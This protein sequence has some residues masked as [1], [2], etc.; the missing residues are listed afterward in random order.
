MKK[1]TLFM[2]FILFFTNSII[3]AQDTFK[4]FRVDAMIGGS[5]MNS[6]NRGSILFSLEPK[7]A[8]ATNINIGL[9][10]EAARGTKELQMDMSETFKEKHVIIKNS[11]VQLTGEYYFSNNAN[12]RP[13]VGAALGYSINKHKMQGTNYGEFFAA[14]NGYETKRNYTVEAAGGDSRHVAL[15]TRAGIEFR[16]FRL[17]IG[18]TYIPNTE[19]TETL[20]IDNQEAKSG[21]FSTNNSYFSI[22]AGMVIGGGKKRQKIH[23]NKL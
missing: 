7:Y 8:I 14:L 11:L 3:Q 18:Y 10:L 2:L 12:S 21:T 9:R 1:T 13:F 5:I 4:P 22:K 16:H 6:P 17:E 20:Y 15:T 19:Y 23:K